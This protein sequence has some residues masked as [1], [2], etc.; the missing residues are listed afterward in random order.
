MRSTPAFTFVA[1]VLAS[2]PAAAQR[3]AARPAPAAGNAAVISDVSSSYAQMEQSLEA[4]FAKL[5]KRAK[6][7]IDAL[8]DKIKDMER[9]IAALKDQAKKIEQVAQK[10]E[11]LLPEIMAAVG[12]DSGGMRRTPPAT[13]DQ[14]AALLAAERAK[15]GLP[16]TP[17]FPNLT[18]ADLSTASSLKGSNAAAFLSNRIAQQASQKLAEID[19][20]IEAKR[21]EIASLKAQIV[22]LDKQL[23]KLEADKQ[24]AIADLKT[25]KEKA[26]AE[27]AK[28]QDARLIR[29]PTPTP[30]R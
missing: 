11:Q 16:E 4:Q 2:V 12:S 19:K 9:Q 10:L 22:E 26:L 29:I 18:P 17:G 24:K 8:A 15:A 1:L 13:S 30:K 3:E 25:K 27:A 6:D 20:A 5:K 7:D 28:A 21:K 23:A 14:L